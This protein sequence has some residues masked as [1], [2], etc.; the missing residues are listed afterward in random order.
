LSSNDALNLTDQL[1]RQ[2]HLSKAE[3]EKFY[4][5][6]EREKWIV[7]REDVIHFDQV[8]FGNDGACQRYSELGISSDHELD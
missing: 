1:D 2:K 8:F 5:R 7:V 4:A 6:L 3:A